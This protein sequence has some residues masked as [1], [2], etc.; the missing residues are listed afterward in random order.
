MLWDRGGEAGKFE[1]K[2]K[3]YKSRTPKIN[4]MK[5]K[6]TCKIFG[7]YA[8]KCSE[9]NGYYVGQTITSF[10]QRWNSHRFCWKNSITSE[11]NDRGTLKL[12]YA[13]KHLK[14]KSYFKYAYSVVFVDTAAKH[15]DLA[16]WKAGGSCYLQ[17]TININKTILPLYR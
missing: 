12:H 6:L 3:F 7:V 8:A 2:N 15:A 5:H 16:F 10:S 11:T 9:C 13:H 4:K 1:K 14:S 17:A